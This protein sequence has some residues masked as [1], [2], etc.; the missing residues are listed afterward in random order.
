MGKTATK[1][2]NQMLKTLP[3]GVDLRTPKGRLKW[4]EH[5]VERLNQRYGVLKSG[6]HP[7]IET[8]TG[9]PPAFL[10][11]DR[12]KTF[13]ANDLIEVQDARG[14]VHKVPAVTLWLKSPARRS[15]ERLQFRPDMH[16][17]D[18]PSVT[19]GYQEFDY[20]LWPGWAIES[21]TIGSCDLILEH[22]RWVVCRGRQDAFDYLTQWL[23]S[24]VQRPASPVGTGIALRGPQG[25]GKSTVPYIMGKILGKTCLS[26]SQPEHLS[27]KFNAHHEGLLLLDAE[28]AFFAGDKRAASAMKHLITSPTLTVERKFCDPIEIPNYVRVIITSNEQWIVSLSFEDRRWTVLDV[29]AERTGDREYFNALYHEIAGQGTERFFNYLLWEVEVDW[30]R[31]RTPLE[32]GAGRE[33]K[34][35]SMTPV[36]EF[37]VDVLDAAQ[38]PGDYEGR[39]KAFKDAVT[40]AF[41]KWNGD[42]RRGRVVSDA[43]VKQEVRDLLKRWGTL[44]GDRTKVDGRDRK[45]GAVQPR[46]FLLPDV[47]TLRAGFVRELGSE[48]EWGTQPNE[49]GGSGG[50]WPAPGGDTNV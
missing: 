49:S 23:A 48:R 30:D 4:E 32:T 40:D 18:I 2:A 1:L 47:A 19:G 45:D 43:A 46:H 33:Q 11:M 41:V 29:S 38:C 10:P 27:G 35:R 21:S 7:I 26:V 22:L 17:G 16:P 36:T 8:V 39:G 14:V 37:L 20:N 6:A 31:L 25:S 42:R 28:E 50:W 13:L 3:K 9:H 24:I 34:E 15:Y 44:G 5:A 12:L